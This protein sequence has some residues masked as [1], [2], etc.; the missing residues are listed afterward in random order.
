MGTVIAG[1]NYGMGK[2]LAHQTTYELEHL[3]KASFVQICSDHCSNP[4]F[5]W[6]THSF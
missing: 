6:C 4:K 2:H 3:V 1:V 5:R